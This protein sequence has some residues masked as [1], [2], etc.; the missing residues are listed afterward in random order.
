L[1]LMIPTQ[2]NKQQGFSLLEILIA[3]S[4]LA[5]SLGILLKIFSAGVNTSIV[6]E[7]YTAAVQ[8]A[9]SLMAKTGV[10]TPLQE[11]QASGLENKKYHW[12]V[13]VSTFV[14]NPE[15]IDS[16]TIAAALYKIKVIVSWGD[17]NANDRQVELTTIRLINKTL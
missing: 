14:F 17:D 12:L 2:V 11:G 6:A 13:E 8:I 10:E 16:T 9:E 4:I 15:N 3:F 7:D 5:L 1:S